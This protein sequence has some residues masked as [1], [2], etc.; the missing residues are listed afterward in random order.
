MKVQI[1]G[2]IPQHLMEELQKDKPSS[3]ASYWAKPGCKHCHGRGEVGTVTRVVGDNNKIKN[4]MLCV[5]VSRRWKQWQ[6]DWLEKHSSHKSNGNGKEPVETTEEE[7]LKQVQPRLEK[8]DE[9]IHALKSE[10][11]GLTDKIESMPHHS[12]IAELQNKIQ[13]ESLILS[14]IEDGLEDVRSE[15]SE[16]ELKA[17]NLIKEAKRLRGISTNLQQQLAEDMAVWRGQETKVKDLQLEKDHVE[18][19]LN[20]SSHSMRKKRREAA[21]KLE[22]IEARKLR[23]LREN[24]LEP[25]DNQERVG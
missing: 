5:C 8:I 21:H 25:I 15:I 7:R 16:I 22:R 23:V 20:R 24:N 6:D 19:D 2:D 17:D 3:D 12:T 9:T 10:I 11:L 4:S 1:S 14:K 13:D 18:R